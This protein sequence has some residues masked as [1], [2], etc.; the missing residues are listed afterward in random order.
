LQRKVFQ[1][2]IKSKNTKIKLPK[3][4]KED[5]KAETNSQEK[6]NF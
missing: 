4:E 1:F 2:E 3:E 6:L 5:K